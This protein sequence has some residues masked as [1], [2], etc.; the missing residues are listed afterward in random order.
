M[1]Q[2]R[3]AFR[4]VDQRNSLFGQKC[5]TG[6]VGRFVVANVQVKSRRR[7]PHPSPHGQRAR[8]M[9]AAQRLMRRLRLHLLQRE[10]DADAVQLANDSLRPIQ[11]V[12]PQ[13]AQ[14]RLQFVVIGIGQVA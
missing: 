6:D 12:P 11:P 5:V 13:F 14:A 10:P 9:R 7:I 8:N 1:R 2:G 3:D 4:A